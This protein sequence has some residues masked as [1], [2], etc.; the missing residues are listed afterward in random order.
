MVILSP[1]G[2]TD[3][4]ADWGRYVFPRKWDEDVFLKSL[5]R[6]ENIPIETLPADGHRAVMFCTTT[7]PY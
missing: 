2:V 3:P 1:L 5:R 6:S 7:D 4:D